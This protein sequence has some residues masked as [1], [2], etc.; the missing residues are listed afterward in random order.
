MMVFGA[1]VTHPS[2]G[3]SKISESIAAVR[4]LLTFV[5]NYNSKRKSSR[6]M[7]RLKKGGWKFGQGMQLLCGQALCPKFSEGSRI[8]NDT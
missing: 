1:D 2:P 3:E 8:R 6:L 5:S 4:K 7:N